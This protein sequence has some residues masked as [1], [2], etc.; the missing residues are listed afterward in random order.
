MISLKRVQDE[1]LY[2]G[3]AASLGK[4]LR[5][6]MRVQPGIALGW[7]ESLYTSSELL[8]ALCDTLGSVKVVVQSKWAVRSSAIGEDSTEHS[9]AGQHDTVLNVECWGLDQA[10]SKVRESLY[11]KRSKIYRKNRRIEDAPKMGVVIQRMVPNV[12][13]SAVVFTCDPVAQSDDVV[14]EYTSGLGDRLVSGQVS[15]D[16]VIVKRGYETALIDEGHKSLCRLYDIAL[17][18]ERLYNCPVDI[19]AAYNNDE[20]WLCQAR[21]ITTLKESIL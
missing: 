18:I 12:K 7:N 3:K 15:P 20:W 8:K 4:L 21:P 11:N 14:I 13:I 2:G 6:R 10:V 5:A 9:F 1:R 19:E 17:E 16:Q